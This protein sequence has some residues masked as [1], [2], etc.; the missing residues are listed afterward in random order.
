MQKKFWIS[1][2][3][4]AAYVPSGQSVTLTGGAVAAFQLLDAKSL[5]DLT[6][7]ITEVVSEKLKDQ[8]DNIRLVGEPLI[9]ACIPLD[10]KPPRLP[11]QSIWH[12][13]T[14][15]YGGKWARLPTRF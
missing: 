9:V 15:Q 6:A 2:S 12:K 3:V 1:W 4:M 11:S 13:H 14:P 8:H 5:T 10:G 7:Q